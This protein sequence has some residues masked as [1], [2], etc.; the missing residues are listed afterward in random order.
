MAEN[1]SSIHELESLVQ[2]LRDGDQTVR[3]LLIE[4]SCERLR[5]LVQRQLRAFPKVRRWEETGD[6]LQ[7]V[8]LR[9]DRAL[10][11]VQPRDLREFFALSGTLIR[12][13]L[14][15]LKRHYYGPEGMGAHH[16]TRM[17]EDPNRSAPPDPDP[18]APD[19]DPSKDM[20]TMELH[21]RVNE[22][23]DDL[24]EVVNLLIYQGLSQQDAAAVLG[25]S[26]KTVQRNWLKA[27][28]Q[29]G[30]LLKN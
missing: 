30:R 5:K 3:A 12:R 22:L 14:I 18:A 13:E 15:D 24:N 23:P 7:G 4:H 9:L 21:Q 26:S 10:S 2:K 28:V 1:E 25:V 6:V 20:E 17:P 29:L 27:R 19:F 11:K 16:K 8:L